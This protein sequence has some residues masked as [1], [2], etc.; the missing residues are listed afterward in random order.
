MSEGAPEAAR[1][2]R[3]VPIVGWV[4]SYDRSWLRGD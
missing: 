1:I 3:L 2:G 4:R